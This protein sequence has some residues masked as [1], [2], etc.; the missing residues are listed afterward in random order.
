MTS[1]NTAQTTPMMTPDFEL[2]PDPAPGPLGVRFSNAEA[3][4]VII[5]V[6]NH[7]PALGPLIGRLYK[8]SLVAESRNGTVPGMARIARPELAVLVETLLMFFPSK[9]NTGPPYVDE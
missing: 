9:R 5:F 1:T 3:G 7:F 2:L 4:I 6:L 8:L